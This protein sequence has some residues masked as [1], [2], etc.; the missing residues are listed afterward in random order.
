M[1][2]TAAERSAAWWGGAFKS[3]LWGIPIGLALGL[4]GALLLWGIASAFPALGLFEVFKGFLFTGTAEAVGIAP[5]GFIALNTALTVVGNFLNGGGAAVAAA[6]Q[7][8]AHL[9]MKQQLIE[10]AGREYQVEEA[11]SHPGRS[12]SRS[13]QA[14]LDAGPRTQTS[15][16]DAEISRA[17]ASPLVSKAIH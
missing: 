1:E 6:E 8:K 11:L 16:A 4:G 12:V 3:A 5:I 14:L 7:D 9:V 2:L 10:L 13:T 17:E 15:F